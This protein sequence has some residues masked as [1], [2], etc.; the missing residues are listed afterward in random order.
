MLF[1]IGEDACSGRLGEGRGTGLL[2]AGRVG[3]RWAPPIV[4]RQGPEMRSARNG[5]GKKRKQEIARHPGEPASIRCCSRPLQPREIGRSERSDERASVVAEETTNEGRRARECKVRTQ[6]VRETV[7]MQDRSSHRAMDN[8]IE[9]ALGQPLD[10]V[11]SSRPMGVA[12]GPV[13]APDHGGAGQ[14]VWQ[15]LTGALL[16]L[17]LPTARSWTVS[18]P[19][20]GCPSRRLASRFA[21]LVFD[22]T[23]NTTPV[24]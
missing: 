22:G 10:A 6:N 9:R 21:A 16:P 20:N 11:G 8:R 5:V 1:E 15:G 13:Q 23:T 24:K 7:G 2:R 18:P 17:A 4:G 14:P 12:V 3:H 19:G